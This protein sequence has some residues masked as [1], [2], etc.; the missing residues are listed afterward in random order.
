MFR[1]ARA[2]TRAAVVAAV[3]ALGAN[4]NEEEGNLLAALKDYA[5]GVRTFHARTVTALKGAVK[6]ASG[7]RKVELALIADAFEKCFMVPCSTFVQGLLAVHFTWLLDGCDNIGR[8]DLA[9]ALERNL[10]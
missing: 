10:T 5:I 7:Q 8:V 1:Y 3:D 9:Q 6:K 4:A 2:G